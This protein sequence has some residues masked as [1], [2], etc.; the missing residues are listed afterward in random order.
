[1][2]ENGELLADSYNTL[3]RWKNYY[4][5][6]LNVQIYAAEP[7]VPSPS[8]LEVEIAIAKF[9]KNKQKGNDEI[10]AEQIQTGRETLLSEIHKLINS[11]SNREE[12]LD[13]WKE[14]IIVPVH[15]MGDKT[16]YN[17]YCGISCT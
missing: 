8:L 2:A 13:Q 7:L 15:K 4:S 3:Y 12:L 14:S 10:P 16:D 9:K 11:V 17:N 1:M 6:L 5:H